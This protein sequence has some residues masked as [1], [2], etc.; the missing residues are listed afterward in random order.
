M[1]LINLELQ[2][3]KDEKELTT[4]DIV[5]SQEVH[6]MIAEMNYK[7]NRDESFV[8]LNDNEKKYYNF[9]MSIQF[10]ISNAM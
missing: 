8:L 9:W 2:K 6:N 1:K 3:H 7:T 5:T 10:I 4:R